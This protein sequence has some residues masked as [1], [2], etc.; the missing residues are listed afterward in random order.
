[1]AIHGHQADNRS[2][3]RLQTC[4]H[5]VMQENICGPQKYHQGAG[6]NPIRVSVFKLELELPA[7]PDTQES[8]ALR[9]R[10]AFL[11]ANQGM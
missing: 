6:Y 8:G 3:E 11:E 5:I 2:L 4:C 7:K 1:M 9:F 10:Q